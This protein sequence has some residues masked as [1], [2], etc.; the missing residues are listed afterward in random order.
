MTYATLLVHLQTGWPNTALLSVAGQFAERFGAHLIGI[1][2]CQ[3]MMIVSGDGAVCGDVY[4]DDQRQITIDLEAAQSEF[5][6]SLSGRSASLEWRSQITLT[7]PS[8]YLSLEARC[9]DLIMIGSTPA[10]TFNLARAANPGSLV[11]EAG[12]PVFVTP[13]IRDAPMGFERALIGW[14]DTTECRRAIVDALPL[15]QRTERIHVIEIASIDEL[16]AARA[17]LDD[18]VTWLHRHGV[19]AKAAVERSDGHDVEHL[20]RVAH[21]ENSDFIVAG[22]YG[23]SRLREWV[24]GGVTRDLLLDCQYGVLMSH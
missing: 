3:P 20:H 7:G 23:H 4:A 10:D 2:A 1:A 17:R 19:T 15:L 8:H 18:V 12:R 24:V 22:A 14:K 5:R 9:A 21:A 13:A 6:E 16:D 11:M